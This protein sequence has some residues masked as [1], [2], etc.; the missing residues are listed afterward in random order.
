MWLPFSSP[1]NIYIFEERWFSSFQR[2]KNHQNPWR[3][4][5]ERVTNVSHMC[6]FC[7]AYLPLIVL[8][9]RYTAGVWPANLCPVLSSSQLSNG[10][11]RLTAA[12]Q[13]VYLHSEWITWRFR[14]L[15][16]IIFHTSNRFWT[17]DAQFWRISYSELRPRSL[18]NNE[19]T[20][21]DTGM[22]HSATK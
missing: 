19:H 20:Q 6:W 12:S 13:C 18:M 2:C 7:D 16:T 17:P 3:E 8:L 22:G 21:S 10:V 4:L 11:G 14:V 5:G 1:T 9:H 15:E